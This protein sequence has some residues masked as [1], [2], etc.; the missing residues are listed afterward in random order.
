M[1]MNRTLRVM[2]CMAKDYFILGNGSAKV[3][4]QERNTNKSLF[5]EGGGDRK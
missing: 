4:R 1:R 5:S 2:E 3:G